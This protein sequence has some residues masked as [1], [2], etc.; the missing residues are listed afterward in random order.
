MIASKPN[1]RATLYAFENLH[2]QGKGIG[3]VACL[4]PIVGK[5]SIIMY[6]ETSS[7]DNADAPPH[8]LLLSKI[9]GP[10]DIEG[11]WRYDDQLYECTSRMVD[12]EI[13]E[14][15]SYIILWR[16][17]DESTGG[18]VAYAL[19]FEDTEGCWTVWESLMS[20]QEIILPKDSPWC[21]VH[22]T[23]W[24]GFMW[25]NRVGQLSVGKFDQNKDTKRDMHCPVARPSDLMCF[26]LDASPSVIEPLFQE[27]FLSHVISFLELPSIAKL[28]TAM[29]SFSLRKRWFEALA[30]VNCPSSIDNFDMH[31]RGSIQW[32]ISRRVKISRLSVTPWYMFSHGGSAGLYN[33]NG[34]FEGAFLFE[35]FE[36][37]NF[38][39]SL[40]HLEIANC[41][42]KEG[43]YFY[44]TDS[45]N[46]LPFTFGFDGGLR[47]L[48]ASC[49]ALRSLSLEF[50]CNTSYLDDADY[51]PLL[52]GCHQLTK[53]KLKH[54]EF[55]S[56][57]VLQVLASDCRQLEDV[58]IKMEYTEGGPYV[59]HSGFAHLVTH[60]PL[61]RRLV[62]EF[63]W[64]PNGSSK[65]MLASL[66][67]CPLLEELFLSGMDEENT[68]E[69]VRELIQ[70]CNKLT[71][72]GFHK[73]DALKE[74]HF[75]I[76]GSSDSITSLTFDICYG[77][78]G[79]HRYG[80]TRPPTDGCTDNA[81][82]LLGKDGRL[83]LKEITIGFREDG[84]ISD[85]V[86]SGCITD[87]GVGA[88]ATRFA[89]SLE[90]VTLQYCG[91]V[92]DDSLAALSSCIL[93][94]SVTLKDCDNLTNNGLAA[95]ANCPSLRSIIV[96]GCERITGAFLEPLTERCKELE[97]IACCGSEVKFQALA[98][99]RLLRDI[100]LTSLTDEKVA[101]LVQG[102]P[103]L[104]HVRLYGQKASDV[105]LATLATGLPH[106][107]VLSI[108]A[109]DWTELTESGLYN[110]L[111]NCPRIAL[112]D[113]GATYYE[114]DDRGSIV[115][116]SGMKITDPQLLHMILQRK[117]IVKGV[118]NDHKL[119]DDLVNKGNN[120]W[121]YC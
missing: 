18:T 50:G 72:L 74:S 21:S 68:D 36:D 107:E 54:V 73:S 79:G 70:R 104:T 60:C 75:A 115:T 1:N 7:E 97:K 65:T 46:M 117:I 101:M 31:A 35:S 55:L 42:R 88:L 51:V 105:T 80:I 37:A 94:E 77:V 43:C 40:Q 30:L 17:Q 15:E 24:H 63:Y 121:G 5:P 67:H 71:K 112:V 110:L 114:R 92:T 41:G 82:S 29:S 8:V 57:A 98:G 89:G 33:G 34:R 22:M 45:H 87:V 47:H 6:A 109:D 108:H 11:S 91:E 96:D 10:Y 12:I 81:L 103:L 93:L 44:E 119:A 116:P 69:D 32:L 25:Q 4:V 106:L 99:C 16:E 102:C 2:W 62:L 111:K 48:S 113:V 14:S 83:Q 100:T 66:A 120:S 64:G 118:F 20:V 86:V 90:S 39:D 56:D 52:S 58:E 23:R 84:P 76:I 27:W 13:F 95:F 61:L 28:D 26:D 49:K 9:Q 38:R 19:S 59:S 3:N 53:L 78:K 85:N